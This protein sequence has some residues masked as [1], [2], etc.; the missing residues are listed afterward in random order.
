M[1]A[2]DRPGRIVLPGTQAFIGFQLSAFLTDAFTKLPRTAQ[3]LH[4]SALGFVALSGILLM[5]RP[6]YHRIAEKGE[7]NP[8][9]LKLASGFL[10]AAMIP[11][12]LGISIRFL[13]RPEQSR[14][15]PT[16]R[17][18]VGDARVSYFR[19]FLGRLPVR[20]PRAAQRH[21]ITRRASKPGRDRKAGLILLRRNPRPCR[22]S[23]HDLL[24]SRPL[25]DH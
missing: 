15:L 1:K 17:R 23:Q 25:A 12:A 14:T 9:F 6:A 11:L 2:H 10:L 20:K 19:R 7:M 5:T 21:F 18:R 8:H 24:A 13:C 16:D 22:S 3:T 4:L